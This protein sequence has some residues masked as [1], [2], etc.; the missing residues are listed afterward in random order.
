MEFIC[1][2]CPRKCGAVREDHQGFGV[3]GMGAL[4][5]I[6]RASLHHWEEPCISGF[7]GSGTVFFS[8]CSLKC[9][10]CQNY[11]ISAGGFGEYITEDRLYDI[12]LELI[13]QGAHNINL[14][15]PTHYAH[16]LTKVLEKPLSVPVVWNTGGYESIDTL[17]SLSG[18]VS[19]YLTDLKYLENDIAK[20]YSKAE[21]YPEVST[22]AL[23]EMFSQTGR[24][25][26]NDEGIMEKGVIVRHLILPNHLKNTEKV[27]NYIGENFSEGDI[28]FSLMSQYT[29]FGKAKDYPELC[30]RLNQDEYDKAYEMLDKSCICDGF[31]QELSSAEEEYIPNFDLTGVHPRKIV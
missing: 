21:D 10:Y 11:E 30:R 13:D 5:R 18:K 25:Y 19:I 3:C 23:S 24:Y 6:A 22:A 12:F 31:F 16:I 4:P 20:K 17:K 29:P 1:N 7:S 9:A 27:I 15:N 2:I 8:G 14:V 26:I 28:L